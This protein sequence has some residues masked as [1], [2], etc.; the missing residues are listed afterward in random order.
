MK[1]PWSKRAGNVLAVILGLVVG[2]AAGEVL[3]RAVGPAPP[4]PEP[5][6]RRNAMGYRDDD[7]ELAKP[8]G[9]VRIAFVGDSYTFGSGVAEE[10]RFSNIVVRRLDEAWSQVHVEGLN[11]GDGGADVTTAARRLRARVPSFEPDAIVYGF[12]LNDFASPETLY[13]YY[14]RHAALGRR[15]DREWWWLAG[16]AR[17]S[18]V[19]DLANTLLKFKYSGQRE[20]QL[21]YLAS[22]YQPGELLGRGLDSL[23]KVMAAMEK[24]QRGIVVFFPYL[25]EDEADLGFYTQA[26][27]LVSQ[28]AQRHGITFIEVLPHL[29]DHPYYDW[30]VSQEDH[31]PNA[32]AHRITA[33]LIAEAFLAGEPLGEAASH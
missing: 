5:P 11:F 17:Y 14:D 29:A 7:H 3:T 22:L 19:A 20:N 16:A 2:L 8:L 1:R 18:Q 33:S 12:V 32:A 27:Y 6:V 25:L 4:G 21:E 15:Y 24:A 30:W 26:R 31:H 23:R 10:D 13:A 28:A 9:V